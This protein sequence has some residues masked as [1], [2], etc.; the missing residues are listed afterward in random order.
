MQE[1]KE[2]NAA[3]PAAA[4]NLNPSP[5]HVIQLGVMKNLLN[6][7][8][9]IIGRIKLIEHLLYHKVVAK[10]RKLCADTVMVI[11]NLNLKELLLKNFEVEM[12]LFRSQL[13]VAGSML[14][15]F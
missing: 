4:M 5:T 8:Y 7:C 12:L 11:I 3:S 14:R 9:L 1:R 6:N 15:M 2:K 13:K 10:N